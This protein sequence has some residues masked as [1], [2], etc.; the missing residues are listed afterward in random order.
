MIN[1]ADGDP[2]DVFAPGYA[3]RLTPNA[4]RVVTRVRRASLHWSLRL[5]LTRLHALDAS[6]PASLDLSNAVYRV[7]YVYNEVSRARGGVG[8]SS[9]HRQMRSGR[10]GCQGMA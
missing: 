2:W 4:P 5:N 7:E 3:F 10:R 6:I 8:R 9:S 1:P